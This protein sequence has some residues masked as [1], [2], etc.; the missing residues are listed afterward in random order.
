VNLPA[1]LVVIKGTRRYVGSE[2]EDASG[3]QEYERSTCLQVG[4]LGRMARAA[5]N[6]CQLAAVLGSACMF[7]HEG[8]QWPACCAARVD[9]GAR[10]AATVRHRGHGCDHD[11][12]AGERRC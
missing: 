10:G 11:T 6:A 2:A 9:G 3:Y 1:R 4:R 7:L 12:E 8:A 5:Q